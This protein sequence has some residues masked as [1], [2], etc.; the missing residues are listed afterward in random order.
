[1]SK[2]LQSREVGPRGV[3]LYY[4]ARYYDSSAGRF[5]REDPKRFEAS[6]TN[7][8]SYARNNPSTGKDPYGL[9]TINLGGT[10][11]IGV[12]PLHG[13]FGGGI[14]IGSD[15][16]LGTYLTWSPIPGGN[17]GTGVSLG[18]TGGIS[19]ARSICG[20][21]GPFLETGQNTGLGASEGVA[22]YAGN[23]SSDGNRPVYGGSVTVGAGGGGDIY[24]NLT[25]TTVTPIIHGTASACGCN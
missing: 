11:G 21:G 7:F 10:G 16:S 3:T 12:G 2:A 5:L 1:M 17:V 14:V 13:Q 24:S 20:F 4:R 8:Y 25:I 23:D 18:L 15:G 9:W 22:F 6:S 19:T